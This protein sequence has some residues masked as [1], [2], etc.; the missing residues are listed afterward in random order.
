MK[1]SYSD[2]K[3]N[4]LKKKHIAKLNKEITEIKK[5]TRKKIKSLKIFKKSCKKNTW[6]LD[7]EKKE[8]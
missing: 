5:E 1:I 6:S 4:I 7:L 8:K 2:I 3:L